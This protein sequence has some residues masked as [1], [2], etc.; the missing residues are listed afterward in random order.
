MSYTIKQ[1]IGNR[2]YAYEVGSYC[3]KKKKQPRQKR[4][5][6]GRVNSLA[7]RIVE[8]SRTQTKYISLPESAKST[9]TVHSDE[10]IFRCRVSQFKGQSF[11]RERSD[12]RVSSL[13]FSVIARTS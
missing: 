2:I 7:G 6:L 10:H 11:S 5:Y 8:T 9:G 13:S 1:K 12:R 3:D 4:K